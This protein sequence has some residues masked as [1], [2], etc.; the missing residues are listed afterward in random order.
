[1][2]AN[3]FLNIIFFTSSWITK[4]DNSIYSSISVTFFASTTSSFSNKI[5]FGGSLFY[6]LLF[7]HYSSFTSLDNFLLFI[8]YFTSLGFIIFGT[9]ASLQ[10]LLLLLL[11]LL[12]FFLL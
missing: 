9:F 12:V 1:M 3:N 5:I 8:S 4:F 7:S 10:L 6:L 2:R 11:F